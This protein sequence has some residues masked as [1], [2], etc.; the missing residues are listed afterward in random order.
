MQHRIEL[1]LSDL[2]SALTAQRRLYAGRRLGS[3]QV[4]PRLIPEQQF[5]SGFDVVATL[6]TFHRRFA[7]V[8]LLGSHLT[9]SRGA[10]SATLT[11]PAV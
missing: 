5:D 10:F 9:P 7:H 3:K 1:V 2:L 4:A 6:S 11:T 8:R